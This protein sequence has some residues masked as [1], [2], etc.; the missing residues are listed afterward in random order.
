MKMKKKKK[1]KEEKE[2]PKKCH[3]KR[4]TLAVEISAGI[5]F[6]QQIEIEPGSHITDMCDPF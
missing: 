3:N 5:E 4:R 2:E 6:L 1:E